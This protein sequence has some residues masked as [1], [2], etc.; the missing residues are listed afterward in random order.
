M[1]NAPS[2]TYWLPLFPCSLL[3]AV[4]KLMDATGDDDV[5]K[6]S[7]VVLLL[8]V[9][10]SRKVNLPLGPQLRRSVRLLV[11]SS[12]PLATLLHNKTPTTPVPAPLVGGDPQV[13]ATY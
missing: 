6:L 3:D 11:C 1:V 5:L 13:S 4:A 12:A 7:E 2:C 8:I 9:I 10:S